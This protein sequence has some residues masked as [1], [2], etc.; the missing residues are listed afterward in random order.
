MGG[1]R[2]NVLV[3]GLVLGLLAASAIVIAT[4]PTVLGLDLRGGTQLIYQASP[5]PQTPTITPEAIDRAISIIRTRTDKFGVAEPE[6]SRLGAKGIQ[7]GLPNVQNAQQAIDQIGTTAQL[8]FYDLEANI[9]PPPKAPQD[10]ASEADPNPSV[11]TFPNL[12][13]AVKFASKRKPECVD[14]KCTTSAPT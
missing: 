13:E 3:I 6:I 11:Y 9:V 12:Y 5:T 1:R 2:R 7:V 10:P 14:N 8:Y 4:K